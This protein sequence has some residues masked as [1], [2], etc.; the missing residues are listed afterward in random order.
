MGKWGEKGG[1][2]E[3]TFH[4]DRELSLSL[5]KELTDGSSSI[6]IYFA[7]LEWLQRWFI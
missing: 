2:Q 1:D 7:H 4:T 6:F 5:P 3:M